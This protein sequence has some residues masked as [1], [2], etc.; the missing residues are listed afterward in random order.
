M[1]LAKVSRQCVAMSRPSGRCYNPA[2]PRIIESTIAEHRYR[3]NSALLDAW[4]ALMSER[5]YADITLTLVAEHAGV[6]RNT[7]YGYYADKEA[8]L[9]AYLDREVARFMERAT[10]AMQGKQSAADRLRALIDLQ[11]GYF[12]ATAASRQD[13]AGIL[14]PHS[15]SQMSAAFTPVLHLI[16][17]VL[18]D[19]RDEGIFREVDADTTARL[20]FGL[21]GT[22][23]V[24]LAEGTASAAQ[25]SDNMLDLLLHG[26]A[27]SPAPLL[28]SE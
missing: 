10:A 24:A 1:I 28:T 26:I 7:V 23:R 2:M 21:L 12:A 6:A 3:I 8:L 13:L 14:N 4:G 5:G 22:Y 17:R 27:H 20:I 9:L 25:V 19:G 15:F 18:Q 16:T 11:T